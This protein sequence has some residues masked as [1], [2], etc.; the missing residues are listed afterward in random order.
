MPDD[1]SAYKFMAIRI[2][3][4]GAQSVRV[5]LIS[6]GQGY[7]LDGGYPFATIRL[8]PASILTNSS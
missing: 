4:K 7:D 2:F 1:V 3:A 6:R 5:E 8:S